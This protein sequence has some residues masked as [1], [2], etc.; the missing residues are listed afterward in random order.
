MK[1]RRKT[2]ESKSVLLPPRMIRVSCGLL[3][4]IVWGMLTLTV[5]ELP[6]RWPGLLP[7][8]MSQLDL[9]GVDHPVTAVLL[10]F[11]GYDTLL[12]IAVLFLAVLGVWSLGYLERGQTH[13]PAGPVLDT[14]V[15]LLQPTLILVSGYLLWR[16]AHAPGGAFQAGAVLGTAGVLILLSDVPDSRTWFAW[17]LKAALTGGLTVFLG[18]AAVPV[19]N[20]Q[21]LLQYPLDW[22]GMLILLVE[23]VATVSIG[24]TLCFLFAGGRPRAM[25]TVIS[26]S[27]PEERE[28]A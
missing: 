13:T 3:L 16:G 23:S 19:L 24:A 28:E 5:L 6:A 14:L 1:R 25:P 12:E 7:H 2:I 15:R 10:N 4:F 22:A 26:E 27:G 8:V 17:P 11:R 21:A 18:V 20:G 9:S